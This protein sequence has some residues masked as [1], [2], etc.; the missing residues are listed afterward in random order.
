MTNMAH[1]VGCELRAKLAS[2]SSQN[3]NMPPEPVGERE[4]ALVEAIA[5]VVR[6]WFGEPQSWF[7]GCSESEARLVGRD[8]L[9]LLREH[10]SPP[11]ASTTKT[12]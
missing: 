10:Q 9:A 8:V 6:D 4:L 2:L 3:L 11:H 7:R 1:D 12:P 5:N